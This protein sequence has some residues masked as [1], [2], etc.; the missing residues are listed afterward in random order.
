MASYAWSHFVT[1]WCHLFKFPHYLSWTLASPSPLNPSRCIS[2]AV[3]ILWNLS[4]LHIWLAQ[5]NRFDTRWLL[6]CATWT[7]HSWSPESK[8]HLAPSDSSNRD[9]TEIGQVI[10]KGWS[11]NLHRKRGMH[12]AR[13]PP[14]PSQTLSGTR[15]TSAE[16]YQ[17]RIKS[18]KHNWL[19][20]DTLKHGLQTFALCQKEILEQ[21]EEA[22]NFPC[23]S[24]TIACFAHYY[25]M[26]LQVLLALEYLTSLGIIHRNVQPRSFKLTYRGYLKLSGFEN[27]KLL[28]QAK[29]RCH[30]LCGDRDYRA[31]EITG[32]RGEYI[33]IASTTTERLVQAW[34]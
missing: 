26:F 34:A 20:K 23:T 29:D 30:T 13:A 4:P 19:S 31:P 27:A 1:N 2:A 7:M 28:A 8:W 33:D 12:A 10:V 9:P 22:W 32:R 18:I 17:P 16:L 15:Q 3:V 24:L 14:L 25:Y 5:I 21:L 6:C 11:S